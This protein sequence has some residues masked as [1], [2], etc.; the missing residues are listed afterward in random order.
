MNHN[1]QVGWQY[2]GQG[3]VQPGCMVHP[4]FDDYLIIVLV[5]KD[6]TLRFSLIVIAGSFIRI[7]K[8]F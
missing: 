1:R 2:R 6:A 3:L 5:I 7:L 4:L 8:L